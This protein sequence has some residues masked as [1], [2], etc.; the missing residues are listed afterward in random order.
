M[1]MRRILEPVLAERAHRI[2]EVDL[3]AR[4]RHQVL[5]LVLEHLRTGFS[6][7]AAGRRTRFARGRGARQAE[8]GAPRVHVVLA[9]KGEHGLPEG[10]AALG[11]VGGGGK[12]VGAR[13]AERHP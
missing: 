6:R 4:Q 11:G 5:D 8:V 1:H 2:V 7:A 12:R 9:R 10:L 3:V 13:V